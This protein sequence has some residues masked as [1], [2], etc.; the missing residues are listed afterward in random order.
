MRPLRT[1]QYEE[2]KVTESDGSQKRKYEKKMRNASAIQILEDGLKIL[3]HCAILI[4]I[5]FGR[6]SS[7]RRSSSN[8]TK[9]PIGGTPN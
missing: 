1:F 8:A 7:N 4:C 6:S 5:H 9:A 3:G 2:S